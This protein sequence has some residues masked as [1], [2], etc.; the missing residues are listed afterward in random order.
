[1]QVFVLVKDSNEGEQRPI[2]YLDKE[3]ALL[4]GL[5]FVCGNVDGAERQRML[6]DEEI[7]VTN[8]GDYFQYANNEEYRFANVYETT[9]VQYDEHGNL[10]G[11]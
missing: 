11:G 7:E 9:V 1:M 3:R 8:I 10:V 4:D 2:A 5:K 6:D